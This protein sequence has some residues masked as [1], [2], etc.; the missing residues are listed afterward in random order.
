[1]DL[2]IFLSP[3]SIPCGEQQIVQT[4]CYIRFFGIKSTNGIYNNLFKNTSPLPIEKSIK[5]YFSDVCF[6]TKLDSADL[7]VVNSSAN[8]S[9]MLSNCT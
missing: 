5:I 3:T 9:Q 1:M 6:V 7:L 4:N 2:K 8:Q